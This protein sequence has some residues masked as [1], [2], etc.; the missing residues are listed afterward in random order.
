[1]FAG[2]FSLEAA[3]RVCAAADVAPEDVPELVSRLA[4]ASMV[5]VGAG[6]GPIR[7][8]LLETLRQFGIESAAG[9]EDLTTARRRHAEYYTELAETAATALLGRDEA[10]AGSLLDAELANLRAAHQ[11]AIAA[12]EADLAV[13]LVAALFR[14]ALWRLQDELFRWAEST[15]GIAGAERHPQYPVVCGMASWGCGL[16]GER[17]AATGYARRG[18]AATGPDD[19]A[20][21]APLE[22]LG[23]VALWEGRLDEA[24][25]SLRE[26]SRLVPDRRDLLPVQ[27]HALALTY[28]GR[29]DEALA[30]AEAAQRQADRLGN[31][32]MR[33]VLRFSRGEALMSRDPSGAAE[34][35]D[36][37]LHLA[38]TV[39]NRLVL[40]VAG[41]SATSIRARHGE[42][43]EALRSF[44]ATIDLWRS[45]SDWTHLWIG[46]RAL[47]ELLHRIGA[48]QPAAVLLGA[49]SAAATAAPP[50][51]EDAERLSRLGRSLADRLGSAGYTEAL[52]R[53]RSMPDEQV[54]QYARA[55]IAQAHG[56]RSS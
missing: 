18:L 38:G 40:G 20:R 29:A 53:G 37:A 31:P 8:A 34:L 28:D 13:R 44:R 26:A 1:M 48:D 47:V 19:P 6:V 21:F 27:T 32:S 17:E 23:H 14:Y 3:E 46:L 7:Y 2:S 45:T 39:Q 41:V 9:E 56:D 5:L 49:V 30:I 50:Y 42:P 11:W 35:L 22:A 43:V 36:E 55:A 10:A 15:V 24:R 51:G 4:D 33:A 54:I 25:D 52:Q 12:G 16:R